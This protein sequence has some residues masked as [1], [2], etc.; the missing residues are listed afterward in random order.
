MGLAPLGAGGRG[1]DRRSHQG[2]LEDDLGLGRGDEPGRLR[3]FD[4]AEVLSFGDADPRDQ[5]QIAVGDGGQQQHRTV[6]R[7][8]VGQPAAE[9]LGDDG[10]DRQREVARLII[11]PGRVAGQF[12]DRQWIASGEP[13]QPLPP[14]TGQ[15]CRRG[16]R[17]QGGGGLVVE[18]GQVQSGQVGGRPRRFGG[19]PARRQDE[20][21]VG[22]Q[23]APDES[24]GLGGGPV[25]QVGVVDDEADRALFGGLGDQGQHPGADG[26]PVDRPAPTQRQ[27]DAEGLGLGFGE[28]VEVIDERAQ[29]AGES[30][31]R[32]VAFDLAA[33]DPKQAER[34]RPPDRVLQQSGLAD[35]RITGDQQGAATTHRG[36]RQQRVDGAL[37]GPPTYQHVRR[38]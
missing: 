5:G 7:R 38:V 13:D 32:E 29:Q 16:R 20:D 34:G 1:V 24:D 6:F 15:R 18:P 14:G 23:P 37:L 4:G 28:P 30:G 3:A 31:E 33:G 35:P 27:R 36:V 12:A 2:V 21:R 17:G 8:Q 19:G 25:D 11:D 9:G 26:E 10:R 22:Q